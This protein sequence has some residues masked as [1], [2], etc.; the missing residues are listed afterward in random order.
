MM[1][2]KKSG[3][4][5]PSQFKQKFK[6]PF[7]SSDTSKDKKFSRENERG[8][9][10][11]N[12][13]DN[14]GRD[15]KF[16]TY[17]SRPA[18]S[19]RP[20]RPARSERPTRSERPVRS[21]RPTR[22]ERPERPM[23][24]RIIDE[25]VDNVEINTFQETEEKTHVAT[26]TTK[27]SDFNFCDDLKA[28]LE[29]LS[30]IHPTPIQEKSI[31]LALEGKDIL[32]S[33]QTGTGK[34][35]AFT[36]PILEKFL[37]SSS[38]DD[39]AI[40]LAPTRELAAQILKSIL[41][42]LPRN[43]RLKT[44]L[45]IGGDPISKQFKSLKQYPQLVV[46]TPGRVNDH[47]KR[48]S[49]NLKQ[50]RFLVL[51]EADRM[52]DM[53]F[54]PQIQEIIKL[55]PAERQTFLFS[56]TLSP[57]IVKLSQKYLHHPERVAIGE[58][59]EILNIRQDVIHVKPSQKYDVLVKELDKREGSIIIFVKTKQGAEDL[60]DKLADHEHSVDAIHGDLQQRKRERVIFAFRN[61]RH[62]ILVATDVA[63]RGLD[64][65]HIEHVINYDMPQTPEDY[66]HRI[67][68]T[69]RAGKKGEAI[70]FVTPA[71]ARK[72]RDIQQFSQQKF[73]HQSEHRSERGHSH[74]RND[75]KPRF[76]KF[77]DKDRQQRSDDKPRF[78]PKNKFNSKE[79]FKSFEKRKDKR[80]R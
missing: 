72:W 46:G 69:A 49:L 59:H 47:L 8:N 2:E 1:S 52:M 26:T 76:N 9:N 42:V 71:D 56:A 4:K 31:P 17:Q 30:F 54:E 28:S 45:L 60:A 44:A 14:N 35:L 22:S 19:E 13:R 41:D 78:K 57:A 67:G 5:S 65:P 53:G 29:R 51:D 6:K 43:S 20:E 12:S 58:Q 10:R 48:R 66:K 21:E 61:K 27:F 16:D 73:Q 74:P 23:H 70:S 38:R 75:Q 15:N 39:T 25:T 62:R 77:K 18:R 34:T 24:P 63:A 3:P 7:K 33:A 64:I 80:D 50:T 79:K 68:R 36:L 40:I 37:T 32:G 11:N 55:L